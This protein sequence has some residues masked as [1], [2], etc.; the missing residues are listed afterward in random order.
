MF[1]R[2]NDAG[3]DDEEI[4]PGDLG[5]LSHLNHIGDPVKRTRPL[6]TLTRKS[7]KPK[8]LFESEED[9][10][11]REREKEEEIMTDVEERTSEEE[12]LG[13]EISKTTASLKSRNDSVKATEKKT[14]P[15]DKWPR[16]KNGS[17]EGPTGKAVKRSASAALDGSPPEAGHE[18]TNS[19]K[20]KSRA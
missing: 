15:F 10:A 16:L 13:K 12:G 1:R 17:R 5:L 18:I 4:D 9:K 3:D 7:I 14:S 11:A 6:R 20:R 8:R 19:S 2:F